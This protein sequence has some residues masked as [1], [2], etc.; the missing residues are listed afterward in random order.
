MKYKERTLFTYLSFFANIGK[1]LV[2]T[3]KVYFTGVSTLCY[4][5]GLKDPAHAAAGPL[6]GA[7]VETVVLSEIVKTL[8]HRGLDPIRLILANIRR[9]RSGFSGGCGYKILD[10]SGLRLERRPIV[11]IF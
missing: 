9:Q 3:P 8:M 2:K 11:V 6:G 1:R 7:I 4:L 5:S 10:G